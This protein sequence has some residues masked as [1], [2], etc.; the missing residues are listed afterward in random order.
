MV[1]HTAHGIVAEQLARLRELAENT[2]R[3][4][5]ALS[6]ELRQGERQLDEVSLQRRTAAGPGA[7]GHLAPRRAVPRPP[8]DKLAGDLRPHQPPP[9][10]PEPPSRQTANRT[11]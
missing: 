3:A 2:R 7:G 10:Q 1:L 6:G 9:Q 11:T 4:G 8:F 5:T